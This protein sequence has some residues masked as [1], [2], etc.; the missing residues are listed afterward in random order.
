MSLQKGVKHDAGKPQAALL[1]PRALLAVARV[2]TH[3]AARYG[4]DNWK[5]LFKGEAGRPRGATER[6]YLSACFRHLLAHM[7]GEVADLDTGESH[8]AHAVC[9]LLFILEH[10]LEH[11]RADQIAGPR[12]VHKG[13]RF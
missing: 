9:S 1:P 12:A 5:Q 7:G 13:G 4:D 2:L 6:R 11:G 10:N 8:L 3:G